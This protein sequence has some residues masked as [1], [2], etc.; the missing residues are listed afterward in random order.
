MLKIIARWIEALWAPGA[1][2]LAALPPSAVRW[3]LFSI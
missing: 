1:R 2:Q 3:A